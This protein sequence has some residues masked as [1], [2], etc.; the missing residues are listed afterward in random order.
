MS[1]SST[2]ECSSARDV[3]ASVPIAAIIALTV[4]AFSALSARSCDKI[5]M[6]SGLLAREAGNSALSNCLTP[7]DG[8]AMAAL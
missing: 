7:L 6:A 3:R 5:Y 2:S 8:S 4:A 1:V